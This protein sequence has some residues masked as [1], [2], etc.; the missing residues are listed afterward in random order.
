M[1]RT[2]FNLSG[3][4]KELVDVPGAIKNLY[5]HRDLIN[6]LTLRDFR[7]RFRGSFGGLLWSV[8][9][10]L[11]MMLVYTLVFSNFLGVRFGTSDSPFMFAVYL[12]C[13]LLPWNAFSEGLNAS[14]GLI[15]A[16]SNLVKRVV[17]PLEVLPVTVTLGAAIQQVIGVLLLIPL[18]WLVNGRF[19]WTVF[20]FPVLLLVQIIFYIGI[21]W[22][23][24]SLSVFLPDLK[25]FT[26]I[27]LSAFVFL[28]PIF[29]PIEAVP[30]EAVF[31]INLNPLTHLVNMY[32][33]T[34]MNGVLP[35]GQEL[36]GIFLL[37]AAVFMLGYWWF[38]RTKK[39]FSDVL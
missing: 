39:G 1:I 22:I 29:Y 10:P 2:K 13:G 16:N 30:P 38:I 31:Y 23:W 32:R 37:A 34:L 19:Y 35:N 26:G 7:A 28:T 5:S 21:N 15:R 36:L 8:F 11:I 33:D 3:L 4:L 25:Q 6:I 20:L 17:F 24:T 18:A 9:Q 27:F 14:T 12:L